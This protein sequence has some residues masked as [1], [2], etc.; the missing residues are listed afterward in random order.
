[1]LAPIAWAGK[2]SGG[3]TQAGTPLS[4]T[5]DYLYTAPNR[6]DWCLAED[7]SHQRAWSGALNGSFAA[8]EQLCNPN[9]DYY[10]GIWWNAGG[11]GIQASVAVVGS[12]SDLTITSPQGAVHHAVLTGSS[13]VKG[14]TTNYYELCYVPSWSMITNTGGGALSGGTWSITLSGNATKAN[15]SLDS[16]MAYVSWQQQNCPASEQNLT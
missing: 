7:D 3:K 8:T 4:P 16:E 5:S 11:V 13:T 14:V 6:P 9:V 1:V 15:Y 12:L 2:S 10:S